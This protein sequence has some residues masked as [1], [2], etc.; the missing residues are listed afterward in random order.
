MGRDKVVVKLESALAA[1]EIKSGSIED[2]ISRG[3]E[4]TFDGGV[5][6]S[7]VIGVPDREERKNPSGPLP[8][9]TEF[10]LEI[11]LGNGEK[12]P[13]NVWLLPRPLSIALGD[14]LPPSWL[15]S[16]L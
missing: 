2:L 15:W 12:S 11:D 3:E 1:F 16:P 9:L 4:V 7:E 6:G 5:L 10:V 13:C 8:L 14:L